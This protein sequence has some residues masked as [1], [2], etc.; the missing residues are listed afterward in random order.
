MSTDAK[1]HIGGSG[2]WGGGGGGQY[3]FVLCTTDT[4]LTKYTSV[5]PLLYIV[6]MNSDAFFT[7]I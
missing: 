7:L 2:G 6:C 3:D 5:R 1:E 4:Q